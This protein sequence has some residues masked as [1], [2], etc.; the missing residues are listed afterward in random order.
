LKFRKSIQR[1]AI[2]KVLDKKN[3]HPSVNEIYDILRINFPTVSLATIY[4]NVEQLCR[5]GKINQVAIGDGP[6]KYDGNT[7]KHTHIICQKCG[8]IEDIWIDMKIEDHI[9][10]KDKIPNFIVTSYEIDFYGICNKCNSS[11]K[12]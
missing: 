12:N 2:L 10:F 4:R 7:Q 9:N 1:D 5:M 6:A 3:Y 8:K 11:G